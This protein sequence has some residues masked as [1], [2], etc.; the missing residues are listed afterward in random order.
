M[1]GQKQITLPARIPAVLRR[2]LRRA[3]HEV[4]SLLGGLAGRSGLLRGTVSTRSF[5]SAS[6]CR[7]HAVIPVRTGRPGA[8]LARNRE[9][10]AMGI[11]VSVV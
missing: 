11:C 2:C 6:Q 8:G 5:R 9:E 3:V 7:Q 10:G 1:E 4:L